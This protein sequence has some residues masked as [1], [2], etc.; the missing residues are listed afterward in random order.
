MEPQEKD[1]CSNDTDKGNII[2]FIK[3]IDQIYINDASKGVFYF[4]EL[5]FFNDNGKLGIQ[6]DNEGR[7]FDGTS[8]LDIIK[9]G[10]F[11]G[12]YDV[13]VYTT[14]FTKIFDTDFDENCRLKDKVKDAIIKSGITKESNENVERPL[15]VFP[16]TDFWGA[17]KYSYYKYLFAFYKYKEEENGYVYDEE[18][19][20][21][22][23]FWAG[24]IRYGEKKITREDS[25]TLIQAFLSKDSKFKN[26][27]EYRIGVTIQREAGCM[28]EGI[29]IYF[30]PK[31][32]E[33]E[34]DNKK[35]E[36][37]KDLGS[38]CL[39]DFE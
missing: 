16:G 7:T 30:H 35:W 14:S 25:E 39:N 36:I 20:V 2:G 33:Y 21:L 23:S 11:L 15:L 28:P 24:Q 13:N 12:E 1:L 17:V 27:E 19:K 9:N 26:Q 38:I 8:G 31:Y 37:R 22:E 3:F 6:D 4:K 10:T 18:S 5:S 34:K 29:K 32:W